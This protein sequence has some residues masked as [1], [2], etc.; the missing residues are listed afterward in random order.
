MQRR[1]SYKDDLLPHCPRIEPANQWN[2]SIQPSAPSYYYSSTKLAIT[3]TTPWPRWTA[4]T[5]A[6]GAW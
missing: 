5:I 4:H 6:T 1:Y 2:V 3:P